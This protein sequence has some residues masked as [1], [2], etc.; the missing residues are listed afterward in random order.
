MSRG[1]S[2]WLGWLLVV[3]AGAMQA[4]SMGLP[5]HLGPSGVLRWCAMLALAFSVNQ[6]LASSKRVAALA[7]AFQCSALLGTVWWIFIALHV[8]GEMPLALS[9]LGLVLL[10]A[11][12][13]PVSYTHLTLPTKA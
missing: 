10:C 4:L 6:A 3:V 2:A 8:Y 9:L 5:Q 12:L 7:Y 13:S 1:L 11:G